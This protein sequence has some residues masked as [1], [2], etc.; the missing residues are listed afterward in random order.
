MR[1]RESKC[2][3]ACLMCVNA[4]EVVKEVEGCLGARGTS[5]F[6]SVLLS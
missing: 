6:M 5:V 1:V 3:I 4:C 2:V